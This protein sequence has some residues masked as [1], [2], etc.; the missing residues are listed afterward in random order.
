MCNRHGEN[1]GVL[2]ELEDFRHLQRLKS[3]KRPHRGGKLY[4]DLAKVSL[5]KT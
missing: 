2:E 5:I 3:Q 1:E 4:L